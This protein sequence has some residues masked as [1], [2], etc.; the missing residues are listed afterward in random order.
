MTARQPPLRLMRDFAVSLV[1]RALIGAGLALPYRLRLGLMGWLTR[2]VLAPLAGYRRRIFRHLALIW[3]QMSQADRAQIANQVCDNAGRT[4]IENYST[5][6][7]LARMQG[8]PIEGPGF[9][10]LTAA[11][12]RKQPV[13]LVSGHFGNYEA[14]RAALVGRGFAIGG[15]YRP[16]SNMFFNEHYVRTMQ[17]FGGPVFPQG[18]QGTTGFVR[19]LKAG[20]QL[21]L[22][23]DQRAGGEW[24]DFLGRPART[25]TSAAE[26]ALRYGALLIPF[27]A[28]RQ[29]DGQ[30]FRIELEAPVPASD[31]LTMTKELTRSL[32]ARVT[33]R[34]GQWFW[35]HERWRLPAGA[36]PEASGAQ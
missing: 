15:L 35:I 36:G 20:G 26:L 13:I 24:I 27:Y 14:A 18:R 11:A 8:V 16:M 32:E 6:D 1:I 29:Q 7:L 3:P 33:A 30:S 2:L 10:A 9:D 4:L 19:H 22:L 17:A 21:V 34:P 23:F 28:T 12:A 31:A 25:A 5:R